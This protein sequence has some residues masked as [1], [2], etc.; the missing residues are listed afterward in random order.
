MRMR[1]IR[2]N[3]ILR[4]MVRE[5]SLSV[6]DFIYPLFLV[7][8]QGIKREITSLKGVYHFSI[9]MLEEEIR[10]IVSL[11]I[12]SVILFGVPD[13]KDEHGS[14]SYDDN[15][16]VQRGIRRIREITRDLVVI[17]D[18]CMC[19]YTS[20]G[21]CGILTED[22]MVDNDVTIDN[23][24][25]IA[26]SHVKAGADVVAPSDMMDFRVRRIREV[27]DEN[28]FINTPIMA[29]S[30]KYA[31]S[32][33]GPFREAAGS[34]P[35]FG[36]RKQYQMDYHNGREA[37]REIALDLDED[38]DF[39]IVKPALAYLDIIRDASVNFN[40]NI[41]AYNVSGEYAMM[42]M[43]VDNGLIAY[44][45]IYETLVSMKR[46]GARTII[47]YHAKEMAEYLKERR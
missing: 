8:G 11:G 46:A 36:D 42:K 37:M 35:S 12:K 28:G 38:A 21:H 29:Y 40:T 15:G 14:G 3:R 10:E 39:I 7:E 47:T 17:T 9:D 1:R 41:V 43:A 4:E 31:S 2:N 25:R 34:T 16:I 30:A 6:E 26:L 13:E 18:V 44:D 22:G 27:L 24:A 32:Y 23:L 5:T 33:Y 45:A 20:H 19:E